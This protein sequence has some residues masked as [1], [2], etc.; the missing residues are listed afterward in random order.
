MMLTDHLGLALAERRASVRL[1]RLRRRVRRECLSRLREH[2]LRGLWWS[3]WL[4]HF[5]APCA[6][7][8]KAHP[9]VLAHILPSL[10]DSRVI[11]PSGPLHW[12]SVE[13]SR[14][15]AAPQPPAGMNATEF[16]VQAGYPVSAVSDRLALRESDGYQED[17]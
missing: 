15:R 10:N 4:R 8:G 16:A 11:R 7:T 1:G 13:V 6:W 5:G 9:C 14:S 3:W 2:G 17:R 12:A